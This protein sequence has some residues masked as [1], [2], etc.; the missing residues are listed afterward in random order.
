MDDELLTSKEAAEFLG[1]TFNTLRYYRQIGFLKPHARSTTGKGR[2]WLYKKSDLQKLV[3][4]SRTLTPT[5][6]TSRGRSAYRTLERKSS[7]EIHPTGC[8]IHWNEFHITKGNKHHIPITCAKCGNLFEKTES[9]LKTAIRKGEFTGC[10]TMCYSKARRPQKMLSD[11]RII[12]DAGYILRHR[13]TF[14][15]DEWLILKPMAK[16]GRVPY[17]LEHRAVYALHLGRPLKQDEI[18]HH[19]NGD[20]ADNRLENLQLLSPSEHSKLHGVLRALRLDE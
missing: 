11:G 2:Y 16:S 5:N 18:P 20:K 7:P 1:V 9:H 8:I 4:T 10:C 15:K 3:E 6:F 19:I 14:T 17:V 12:G 13:R